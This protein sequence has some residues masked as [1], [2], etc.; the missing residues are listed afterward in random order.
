MPSVLISAFLTCRGLI[1]S[2]IALHLEVLALRHQLLEAPRVLEFDEQLIRVQP[3]A[4]QERPHVVVVDDEQ[5]TDRP[6][7]PTQAGIGA[8][9]FA[10]GVV[11]NVASAAMC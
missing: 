10:V 4:V 5:V 2:R 9:R 6:E 8:D 1:R 3:P 7:G 11:L